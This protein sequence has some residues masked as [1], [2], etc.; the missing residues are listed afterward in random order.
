MGFPTKKEE[1]T[2]K[3]KF[4]FTK[5]TGGPPT[6]GP[7]N[8]RG[9]HPPD[10][11]VPPLRSARSPQSSAAHCAAVS[12]WQSRSCRFR[13]MW[14]GRLDEDHLS[15]FEFLGLEIYI[16][17][18]DWSMDMYGLVMFMF[19]HRGGTCSDLNLFVISL[20]ARPCDLKLDGCINAR[21]TGMPPKVL[22]PRD[23]RLGVLWPRE[24]RHRLLS[25]KRL[26]GSMFGFALGFASSGDLLIFWPYLKA[27][28]GMVFDVV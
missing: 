2:K 10:S 25:S 20:I 3:L 21:A 28:W 8:P 23:A 7:T 18:F 13:K 17:S 4:F 27:F 14:L 19:L 12:S 11:P 15:L 24:L 6:H 5:E 26:G 1:E 9:W 16:W 22:G